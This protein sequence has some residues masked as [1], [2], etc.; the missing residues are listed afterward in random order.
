MDRGRAVVELAVV[1]RTGDGYRYDHAFCSPALAPTL[2]ACDYLRDPRTSPVQRRLRAH[3]VSRLRTA[4]GAAEVRPRQRHQPPYA[5][6]ERTTGRNDRV[7][8]DEP[9]TRL[10]NAVHPRGL[11][12]G[13]GLL[14]GGYAVVDGEHHV[15]VGG[16]DLSPDRASC[17]GHLAVVQHEPLLVDGPEGT[18]G[19]RP[20]AALTRSG[21][22]SSLRRHS[23]ARTRTRRQRQH[24]LGQDRFPPDG[25]RAVCWPQLTSRAMSCWAP[26]PPGPR[27]RRDRRP[28]RVRRAHHRAVRSGRIRG[29]QRSRPANPSSMTSCSHSTV[30]ASPKSRGARYPSEAMMWLARSMHVWAET[31]TR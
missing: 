31:W 20:T 19:S 11:G 9:G 28:P 21:C 29:S 12:A 18:L 22:S 15:E 4:R 17:L 30:N 23:G 25:G 6:L 5:V 1:G 24:L 7:V 27:L 16:L 13:T 8:D 14:R 2:L 3:G 26:Q 10:A